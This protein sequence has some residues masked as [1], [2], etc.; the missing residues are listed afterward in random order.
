MEKLRVAIVDDS[1]FMQLILSDIVNSDPLLTVV[2]TGS[3]G[4]EAVDLVRR[5]KPD[6]L[7]LDMIMGEFDG[8]YA[9]EQIMKF[10]PLPIIVVSAL[11]DKNPKVISDILELGAYDFISK[12]N[13]KNHHI[14]DLNISLNSKIKG[15]V[16][17]FKKQQSVRVNKNNHP[18][19]FSEEI[20]YEAIVVGSS[21]GGPTTVEKFLLQLPEN[22]PVPVVIAQHMPANFLKPYAQRLDK[23]CPFPVTTVKT[24]DKIKRGTVYLLS[25][26]ANQTLERK[27]GRVIVSE[28][29]EQF[30]SFNNPSVDALFLSA[31]DVY[32]DKLISIVLTGMGADGR[33]G[34][35]KIKDK[36]G[37]TIAQD[38]ATSVVYGMPREAAETG[39]V[40]HI[41]PLDELGGFVVTCLS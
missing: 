16:E 2:E 17:G 36:G 18:H 40:D 35:I 27:L 24:G 19:T 15:A 41:L 28:T 1:G 38:E 26:L 12:P 20:H 6:V 22:L 32:K 14:R 37:R 31:A 34:T 8:K 30:K 13:G 4:K 7:L 39:K 3:D 5:H 9:I 11:N 10:R 33:D 29:S 21:T 25:G 23:I